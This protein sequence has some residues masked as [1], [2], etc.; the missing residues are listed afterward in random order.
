MRSII[1][2]DK[3]RCYICGRN[4]HF[5]PIDEHHV[6][7]GANRKLSERY[8]LKVY[9]H[10]YSCHL[11]GVHKDGEMADQL[12]KD[13]QTKAMEHYGWTTQDFITIFGKNYL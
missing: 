8:G 6:Y 13:V 11:N 12:K 2:K 9:L 3:G 4:N 5:E 7:A 1:Q 10:H